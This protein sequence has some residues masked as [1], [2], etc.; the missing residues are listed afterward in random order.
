[1]KKSKNILTIDKEWAKLADPEMFRAEFHKQKRD[2]GL[3]GKE[4]I[5]EQAYEA[6][7]KKYK[8]VFGST[9]Y[10]S[11]KSFEASFY[12]AIKERLKKRQKEVE[13]L[14]YRS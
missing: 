10:S 1:M 5:N 4:H 8:A 13:T 9:K 6:V 7:E 2:L 11:L 14:K 3:D 12:R